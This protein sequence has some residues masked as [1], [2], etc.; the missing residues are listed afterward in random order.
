MALNIG[1]DS[2]VTT[3]EAD[4]YIGRYYLSTDPIALQWKSMTPS[5][6][7]V[8]LRKAANTIDSLPLK[9]I[10]ADLTQPLA[11]PRKLVEFRGCYVVESNTPD[12]PSEVK[13]AQIEQAL[14]FCGFAVDPSSATRAELQRQGVE[15][16]SL[17]DLSESYGKGSGQS[18]ETIYTTSKSVLNSLQAWVSGGFRVCR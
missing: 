14:V 12:V 8:L 3:E 5:D 7:E 13:E 6:K 17:G 18:L 2:Y 11:F 16:F 10:K 1:V 4:Q 9:G 15:S